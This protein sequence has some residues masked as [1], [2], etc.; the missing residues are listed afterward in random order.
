MKG[1]SASNISWCTHVCN[2]LAGC[3]PRSAGCANCWAVDMAQR[4]DGLGVE[5]FGPLVQVGEGGRPSKW[6]RQSAGQGRLAQLEGLLRRRAP[7]RVFLGSMTDLFWSGHPD[8]ARRAVMAAILGAQDP[9]QVLTLTKRPDEALAFMARWMEQ[10][11]A[12]WRAWEVLDRHCLAARRLWVFGSE[13]H[14]FPSSRLME[15]FAALPRL[16]DNW[17][18]GVSVEAPEQ[19]DRLRM[20]RLVDARVRWVSAEP[21]LEPWDPAPWADVIDWLV[22]GGES[23]PRARE[24]DIYGLTWMADR[25]QAAGIKVHMKQLGRRPVAYDEP[26]KLKH[27]MGGCHGEW[28]GWVPTTRDYPGPGGRA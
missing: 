12:L 5:G 23:G 20:L 9:V 25:A 18:F 24:C 1:M 21:L 27:P 16:P 4:L 13:G 7:S 26:I 15:R 22:L 14:A 17:W 8:N 3:A 10:S 11:D 6:A 19:T 2:P 28:P